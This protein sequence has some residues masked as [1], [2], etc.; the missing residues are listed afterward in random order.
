MQTRNTVARPQDFRLALHPREGPVL[1]VYDEDIPKSADS[2]R[3]MTRPARSNA[4]MIS[5]SESSPRR[6]VSRARC[7]GL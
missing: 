7:T 2:G 6:V 5:N 1:V 3:R 4:A